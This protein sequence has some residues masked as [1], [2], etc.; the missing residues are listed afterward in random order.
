MWN[1]SQPFF[2]N[3]TFQI[4]EALRILSN[5]H[6]GKCVSWLFKNCCSWNKAYIIYRCLSC[7]LQYWD[8]SQRIFKMN[9]IKTSFRKKYK[10]LI[11]SSSSYIASLQF[12]S[13]KVNFNIW[14]W[15]WETMSPHFSESGSLM[16]IG[17]KTYKILEVKNSWK[18]F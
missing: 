14:H 11:F 13:F 7:Y 2:T 17:F 5:I 9:W 10:L 1:L 6:C 8:K 3:F 4:T 12:A 16:F 18:P 15:N